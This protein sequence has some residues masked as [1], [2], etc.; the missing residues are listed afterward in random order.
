M[1]ADFIYLL[2]ALK[3]PYMLL[4]Q[5]C[6]VILIPYLLWRT[7]NLG[8]WFPLGVI[9]IFSGVLLGPSIFGLAFP[10]LFQALFGTFIYA[11]KPVVRADQIGA[12]ATIAVCLFGF[13]AGADAD[14]E[15]IRKSGKTVFNI[16]IFGMLF[17]WGLAIVAGILIYYGLPA[18]VGAKAN[19]LSFSVA[20]GLVIAV[21]ALPVLALILRALDL[22]RRRL[23][24]V[25][26]ASAGLADTMMWIGLGLVVALALG[27][28]LT[29]ALAKILAGGVLSIGFIL[30][31]AS[32]VLNRMIKN[33]APESAVMTL[34]VLSIFV[35]SAVTAITELHPVL[36]AF[37]A[38]VFLPD[39][40]REM[41]A[42]RLDQPTTLVLMPFFFLFTG[43]RTNFSF[44]DPNIWILFTVSTFLCVF[45]KMV[46]H[47]VA[48]R[49]SG[50]NW[51]F[52]AAVGLLLQTKGLMG[53]IVISVF[54]EK[55]VVSTLM[56]SAAVLMCMF[57]TGLSAIAVK[58]IMRKYG[59]ARVYDGVR[60]GEAPPQPIEETGRPIVSVPDAAK[61]KPALATLEFEHGFGKA[62]ITE[63]R[64]VV[65]RHSNAD[66][67]VS[68]VRVSRHHALIVRV[69]NGKFEVHNQMADRAE[70][71]PI[72][73]NGEV[74]EHAPLK[75]GDKVSLGGVSF[76]FRLA[77]P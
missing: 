49:M 71:N 7:I 27:G 43:L 42:H 21:S 10:D 29:V 15:L 3:P 62:N 51:P 63:P 2:K 66:V 59:E 38:G 48:A 77:K 46:G 57:S 26:L 14:K 17:G 25:A 4:I 67:V 8:K 50:E 12:L 76:T 22:T 54:L 56:F 70:P 47:G 28:N 55:E 39:K 13:L 37:V 64:T 45:G 32:P 1:Y 30:W 36:G 5:A 53:L 68:D 40:V 75:D 11:G 24:A 61:G 41:A 18:A 33:E 19:L 35:A 23:G 73:I 65:G 60:D 74:K 9:Q 31:V 34:A 6:I 20:F 72:L 16:G 52:S 69:E 44:T 58:G